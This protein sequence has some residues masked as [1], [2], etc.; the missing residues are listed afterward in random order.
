M[1]R[2]AW[3]VL[4]VLGSGLL[5]CGSPSD[6]FAQSAQTLR[7]GDGD[8]DGCAMA[9]LHVY[10]EQSF[11]EYSNRY[12]FRDCDCIEDSNGPFDGQFKATIS[13]SCATGNIL[14]MTCY[15]KD[16]AGSW[17]TT[18]CRHNKPAWPTCPP[19]NRIR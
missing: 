4:G 13:K 18:T 9:V 8:P 11:D 16:N 1:R 14:S 6:E 15:V 12:F 3:I 2:A 19:C 10:F 17:V 7:I 5:G